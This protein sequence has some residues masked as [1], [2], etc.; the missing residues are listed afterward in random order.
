M[1]AKVGGRSKRG[2]TPSLGRSP[3]TR[4]FLLDEGFP[5]PEGWDPTQ[6]DE[7]VRYVPLV[8]F[9][10]QL[11]NN[12]TPDWL[13]ILEAAAAGFAGLV[14]DDAAMLADD[15]SMTALSYT[16]LSLVTWREGMDDNVTR[17]GQLMAFMPEISGKLAAEGPSIFRL[18]APRL[19]DERSILKATGLLAERASKAGSTGP[20]VRAACAQSIGAELRRR[21]LGRLRKLLPT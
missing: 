18:P 21:R 20:E 15:L 13:I 1:P 19:R 9:A 7:Q 12:E 6:L 8:K 5:A 16:E 17:W 11:A 4:S 14:T 2:P 10:P 3:T